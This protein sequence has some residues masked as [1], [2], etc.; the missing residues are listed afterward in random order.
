L[1]EEALLLELLKQYIPLRSQPVSATELESF[2]VKPVATEAALQ[3]AVSSIFPSSVFSSV[4]V[5]ST[6]EVAL[7][8]DDDINAEI[9][10]H[11]YRPRS[12]F[13]LPGV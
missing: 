2:L 7:P 10:Q 13:T 12:L 9:V 6:M 4:S 11:L 8:F 3:S 1:A 5:E